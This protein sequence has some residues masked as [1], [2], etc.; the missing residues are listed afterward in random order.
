MSTTTT[1]ILT[2]SSW[3]FELST[4]SMVGG[5]HLHRP[6]SRVPVT[7]VVVKILYGFVVKGNER[8]LFG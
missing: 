8:M 5:L 4:F 2:H 3:C 6:V 7:V 1:H